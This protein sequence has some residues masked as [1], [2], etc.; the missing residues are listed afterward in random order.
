MT[1][2][3]GQTQDTDERLERFRQDLEQIGLYQ[4]SLEALERV[5]ALASTTFPRIED[6]SSLAVPVMAEVLK[7]R[8]GLSPIGICF[9]LRDLGSSVDHP[10][11]SAALD[12]LILTMVPPRQPDEG[13]NY[14]LYQFSKVEKEP[15]IP[16]SFCNVFFTRALGQ[17]FLELLENP[18]RHG[19]DFGDLAQLCYAAEDR[20]KAYK[21]F[22]QIAT[23]TM[24]AIET[25]SE[26][27]WGYSTSERMEQDIQ[28]LVNLH[29]CF[30]QALEPTEG[31]KRE[32]LENIKTIAARLPSQEQRS[33]LLYKGKAALTPQ[34]LGERDYESVLTYFLDS[35]CSIHLITRL[36][37]IRDS[38]TAC[39][40]AEEAR[41]KIVPSVCDF[42]LSMLLRRQKP[43][44]EGPLIP[45][46][47]QVVP[48]VLDVLH[49]LLESGFTDEERRH[50]VKW[51]DVVSVLEAGRG[52]ITEQEILDHVEHVLPFLKSQDLINWIGDMTENKRF[53]PPSSEKDDYSSPPF[54]LLLQRLFQSAFSKPDQPCP[55]RAGSVAA[56]FVGGK[57]TLVF[58]KEAQRGETHSLL[59]LT[60][61]GKII[62]SEHMQNQIRTQYSMPAVCEEVAKQ[63]N[64]IADCEAVQHSP[65]QEKQIAPQSWWDRLRS[66][67]LERN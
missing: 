8:T 64:A 24:K 5:W 49:P 4:L 35:E 37:K 1:N 34:D 54:P 51:F 48:P 56:G 2:E 65:A 60:D 58:A 33:Y 38:I 17:N 53:L 11:Y 26:N 36:E 42:S 15:S 25:R 61:S 62:T 59:V 7:G 29:I 63:F 19:K 52:N 3:A 66:F 28:G 50:L 47:A 10:S 41:Q 45:T 18:G 43:E 27:N 21:A 22:Q 67:A 16:P 46:Y 40:P 57:L 12:S 30:T 55:A 14:F 20:E 6:L 39:F 32:A 9:L 23:E 13:G 44:G 31:I